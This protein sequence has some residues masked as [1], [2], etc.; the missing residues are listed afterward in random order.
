LLC[1]R[2]LQAVYSVHDTEAN[3]RGTDLLLF[4]HLLTALGLWPLVLILESR[5]G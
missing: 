3:V 4:G 5:L 2:S 1:Q